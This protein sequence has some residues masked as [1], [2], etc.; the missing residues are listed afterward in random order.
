MKESKTIIP[1]E[2]SPYVP[3]GLKVIEITPQGILCG[4]GNYP[5]QYPGNEWSPTT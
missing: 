3:A 5:P 1:P 4:S 2:R